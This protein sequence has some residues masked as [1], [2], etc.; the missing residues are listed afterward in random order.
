MIKV[1]IAACNE[2]LTLRRSRIDAA[3]VT[4]AAEMNIA[5]K[6]RDQA[7]LTE[8]AIRLIEKRFQDM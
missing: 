4:C 1:N 2:V 7:S 5:H 6:R 8:A 3:L